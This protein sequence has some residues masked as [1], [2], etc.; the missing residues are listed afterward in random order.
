MSDSQVTQQGTPTPTAPAAEASVETTGQEIIESSD[1]GLASSEGVAA[2]GAK[3]AVDAAQEKLDQAKTKSEKE[4][5]EKDLKKAIHKYKLKVDG[6]EEEWEGSEEDLIRDLQLSRK[7]RKEIKSST[8]LKR[9]AIKLV[10]MLKTNPKMVLKDFGVDTIE[11][12]KQVIREQIEEEAKSPEQRE[13]DELQ[14]ELE[15]LREKNKKEAEDLRQE[16]YNRQVAQ[17]E[18]Q[19]EEQVSEALVSNNLPKS[20]YTLKRITD[21]ML[22]SLE[23]NKE[24][25]AKQAA[26]IVRK[27]MLR[28]LK[29][30]FGASPEDVV[31]EM[32]GQDTLKRLNK[33]QVEK[34]KASRKDAA[35]V[36]E[37]S[38][39]V[40]TGT[41]AEAPKAQP[42]KKQ[43]IQ[44]WL[45]GSKK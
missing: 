16:M 45:Y 24:I 37:K 15:E 23:N 27:E 29:D 12:A 25:T 26:N 41:K 39:V 18:A 5:A 31:E 9:E 32:L 30:M 34:V 20:A 42:Q 43:T 13:R 28:D 11:F 22:S 6:E 44:D 33:R 4:K 1:S 19:L 40:D 36:Q 14:R 7:A 21:V 2:E 35:T 3:E 38:R 10:E 8:E 17:Y